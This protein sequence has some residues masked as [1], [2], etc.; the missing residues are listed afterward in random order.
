MDAV[1][2][3]VIDEIAKWSGNTDD[4][5]L[6]GA[7]VWDSLNRIGQP[8]N[9]RNYVAQKLGT[10]R[11]PLTWSRYDPKTRDVRSNIR[12]LQDAGHN[13]QIKSETAEPLGAIG[14][15]P[16]RRHEVVRPV[17][18]GASHVDSVPAVRAGCGW[19][20]YGSA[21]RAFESRGHEGAQPVVRSVLSAGVLA[22]ENADWT[23]TGDAMLNPS[24]LAKQ[25]STGGSGLALWE[26][27]PPFLAKNDEDAVLE[28]RPYLSIVKVPK[29]LTTRV[30]ELLDQSW[31]ESWGIEPSHVLAEL[32]ARGIGLSSL[33]AMGGSQARGALGFFVALRLVDAAIPTEGEQFVL[34][35][36][37]CDSYITA[38]GGGD[39]PADGDRRRADLLLMRLVNE[40]LVL[41]PIEIK[42]YGLGGN[43]PVLPSVGSQALN[44]PL[45]QLAS[46]TRVLTRLQ[47]ASLGSGALW[48]AALGALV[49]IGFKLNP[50]AIREPVWAAG[51]LS[52]IANGRIPV[53]VGKPVLM[54]FKHGSGLWRSNSG[55]ENELAD[56]GKHGEFV[57]DPGAVA[58]ALFGD[59][60]EYPILAEWSDLINWS[61]APDLEGEGTS[62]RSG[63]SET[64]QHERTVREAGA[65]DEA[66]SEGPEEARVEVSQPEIA[67]DLTSLDTRVAPRPAPG[68][69]GVLDD[70]VR[71]TVGDLSDSM[72][73]ASVDFWPANTALTQLNIGV[74]GNL[75]TGKTQLIKMLV[76]NLRERAEATQSNPV[77]VLI[78]DYKGDF[79]GEDFLDAVGGQVLRPHR[80]PLNYFQLDDPNDPLA[81]V[82]KA[83]SFNDVLNQ[84]FNIGPKQQNTLRRIVVELY[85]RGTSPTIE[86]ILAEYRL[87]SDYDSVVGVLEGW[88]LGEV[89][90]SRDEGL[91]SFSDIMD[92]RVTVLSLL[93]LGAD[94]A[95]KNALVALF[96][97]LYYE[98][99][100]RL[101]KWPYQGE[102]PQLRQLNSYLL[103][104]EAT[105]IMSYNFDSLESLL[106][107]GREFGVGVILSS[108]YLSHFRS[109]KVDYA[110]AL[111]TWFIH[112]V[113]NV[114]VQQL[115][116]LGLTNANDQTAKRVVSLPT[117]HAL[118]SSLGS[119]GRF[120]SGLPFYEWI[121]GRPTLD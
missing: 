92:N 71:F 67:D 87:V 15:I 18:D 39:G 88:V 83:G 104:D 66:L 68:S 28:R 81:A 114:T 10:G 30:A 57:A 89:F 35:I 5:L 93:D 116:G 14:E 73:P 47:N 64:A 27:R 44:D 33:L 109:T 4:G 25:V 108:Q 72:G 99:M 113:P 55:V 41:V 119:P 91:V 54:Y 51:M 111:L 121:K 112:S 82:R 32:G 12:I 29:T 70:G 85:K 94:Q 62:Y 80:L 48:D 63:S 34:P 19:D 31:G 37:A 118:Y 49:D 2:R 86:E 23:I 105:N 101:P 103:V 42:Y 79:V 11:V 22:A 69:R 1:D 26:W 61:C 43:S 84:I 56:L 75:G 110:Q 36:D 58:K 21:L 45:S 8:D 40:E 74:V 76:A 96:L 100:A 52:E 78:L 6:G 24:A 17:S 59:G 107:Q 46:T 13:L 38:L 9:A 77:S 16:F 98:Y 7:R 20:P 50:G 97:N 117:H 3:A 106:L 90:A 95:S 102:D 65:D 115:H 120:I 60:G 53:R